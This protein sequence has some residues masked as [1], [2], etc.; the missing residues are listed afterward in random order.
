[1]GQAPG[2]L[3]AKLVE[4]LQ[5]SLKPK[6]T[7]VVPMIDD[8]GSCRQARCR[9]PLTL[10][11]L[12]CG[13]SRQKSSEFEYACHPS[14]PLVYPV[15]FTGQ[16]LAVSQMHRSSAGRNPAAASQEQAFCIAGSKP[17]ERLFYFTT[18]PAGLNV[19]TG[20]RQVCGRA[21]MCLY[22]GSPIFIRRQ[23][24]FPIMPA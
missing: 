2:C 12:H 14:H 23:R 6:A 17:G 1:M 7:I 9:P 10:A 22:D 21:D 3:T 5:A 8:G 20:W 13:L 19:E 4:I 11:G 15:F 24:D 18:W 16:P